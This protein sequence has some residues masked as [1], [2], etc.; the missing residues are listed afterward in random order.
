[1]NNSSFFK[2]VPALLWQFLF[3]YIPLLF[4][5]VLSFTDA[6]TTG[7]TLKNYVLL[8]NSVYSSII[9][10]SLILAFLTATLCLIIGYPLAYFIALKKRSLKNVFLFF[11]ILPFWTNLLVLTYAWF[12]ILDRDG[13][14]NS[15]LM[16]IG[17]ITEPLAL[18]NNFFA[19]MIVMFYCYL[20]FMIM[21]L[22]SVLEK[23][24]LNLIEASKDL[25]ANQWQTLWNVIIPITMPGIKAG[26]LL[27][28]VPAFGEFV[29]PLLVGGDKY[30]FVGTLISHY[31][32]IGQNKFAGSAFTVLSSCVLFIVVFFVNIFVQKLFPSQRQIRE[33]E[34]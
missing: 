30:M 20:P 9:F 12:F 8:L 26:F 16:N 5:I 22:F 6:T 24:D 34:L 19:I 28:F 11:I 27:V 13:L 7:F 2:A 32:L 10:R 15:L 31:F 21:P 25:G 23:F 18:I 3:F 33:I 4:V 14:L 17:L 29:I 1:M